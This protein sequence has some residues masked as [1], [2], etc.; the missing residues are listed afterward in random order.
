MT[1]VKHLLKAIIA[2]SGLALVVAGL[3]WLLIAGFGWPGPDHLPNLNEIGAAATRPVSDAIVVDLIAIAGWV[4]WAWFTITL[5]G[6]LPTIVRTNGNG[7][8]RTPIRDPARWLIAMCLTAIAI[9]LPHPATAQSASTPT[10]ATAPGNHDVS[11]PRIAEKSNPAQ[12]NIHTVRSN[13]TLSYIAGKRLGDD[14]RWPLIFQA[15]KHNPQPGHETLTDPDLIKPGWNLDIPTPNGPHDTP[16]P[17]PPPPAGTPTP[18]P[19]P[20]DHA[21]STNQAPQPAPSSTPQE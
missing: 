16:E 12:P 17:E 19:P 8:P 4:V 10:V 9:N 15:N 2:F 5:V 14:D 3:P 7:S 21:P 18:Q 20:T 13:E 1:A 11:P 6:E